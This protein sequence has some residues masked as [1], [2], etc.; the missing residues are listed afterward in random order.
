MVGTENQCHRYM[1]GNQY[2]VVTESNNQVVTSYPC[3][4]VT[5]SVR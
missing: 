1:Y 5:E 2:E 4:I 3:K